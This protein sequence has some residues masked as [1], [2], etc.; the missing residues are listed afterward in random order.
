[1]LFTL[2]QAH[3]HSK[4]HLR[5]F[6]VEL[7]IFADVSRTNFIHGTISTLILSIHYTLSTIINE[8][9]L[10]NYFLDSFDNLGHQHCCALVFPISFNYPNSSTIICISRYLLD[11]SRYTQIKFTVWNA[12]ITAEKSKNKRELH[13]IVTSNSKMG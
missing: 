5:P 13:Y 6:F 12:L 3:I 2:F 1:M 4:N 10:L 9:I 11:Q 7:S 8:F